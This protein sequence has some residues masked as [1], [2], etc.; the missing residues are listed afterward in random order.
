[1][2]NKVS[3]SMTRK[4]RACVRQFCIETI[5]VCDCLSGLSLSLTFYS[6][7]QKLVQLLYSPTQLLTLGLRVCSSSLG[8]QGKGLLASVGK[9]TM[10]LLIQCFTSSTT[11]MLHAPV[12]KEFPQKLTYKRNIKVAMTTAIIR[13]LW[14][15]H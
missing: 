8:R 10:H 12:N 14:T 5:V 6:I 15:I 7:L 9:G 13:E 3:L 1:M 2:T 4:H 11:K